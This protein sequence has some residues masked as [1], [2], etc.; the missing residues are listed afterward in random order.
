MDNTIDTADTLRLP[1]IKKNNTSSHFRAWRKAF[2]WLLAWEVY[3]ILLLATFLRFYQC[4]TTEFDGDQAAIYSLARNALTHGLIPVTT[5]LASIRILNPPA[6]VYLLMLGAAF[7]ANPFAGVIVT[8]IFNVLA[9]LFTYLV[10]SRYYGRVAG[11]VAAL[12][13]ACAPLAIFYSGFLWNQNL[14]APFVPLFVWALFWGVI[15]RRRGWLA[16]AVVLWGWMIQ[17]HGSAVLLIIPLGVACLL[18]FKTL[19]WRDL[20]LALGLLIL[21][22]APYIIWEMISHFSDVP[23]LLKNIGTKS[24]IDNL[25]LNDYLSFLMPYTI[26]PTNPLT[27]QYRVYALLHWG[28]RAILLLAACAL[29]FALWAVCLKSRDLLRFVPRGEP[30]ATSASENPSSWWGKVRAWWTDVVETPWRCG[31]IILL[32]W[33]ILPILVLSHHSLRM[34][35]YYLLVLMPGPFILIGIF[36]AQVGE[37]VRHLHF[38]WPLTRF[39]FYGLLILL[40]GGLALGSFTSTLDKA[41]GYTTA[42]YTRHKYMYYTL[43]DTQNAINEADRLAQV[44]H[45]HHVYIALDLSTNDALTYLAEQMQTPYTTYDSSACLLLPGSTQ[46]PALMLFGPGDTL[47]ETT[48]VQFAD[49]RLVDEPARLGGPPFH[50]Y[51]VQPGASRSSSVSFVN[52][53]G[54]LSPHLKQFTWRN[55]APNPAK[56]TPQKMQITPR[57]LTSWTVLRNATPAYGTTYSYMLNASYHGKGMEGVTSQNDCAFSSLQFGEQMLTTFFVPAGTVALPTSLSLSGTGWTTTLS[58]PTYGPFH[59]QTFQTR[60]TPGIPL[61]SSAG[62][63]SI[64]VQG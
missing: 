16:P 25:A 21:I 19:R 49:A 48:M 36:S 17:L 40:A 34:F 37:W 56:D 22:Y 38:P 59:F 9:V 11:G 47:A 12:F 23:I 64:T 53:L 62:G 2:S 29:L 6:T 30:R 51:L 10:V 13:Y 45:V 8:G 39:A 31:L 60:L 46:G 33:Q 50:L 57:L 54:L 15:E 20:T 27:S 24:V 32:A 14:L 28:E 1:R 63:K 26:A 18:A 58:T 3:P 42:H 52:N 43:H 5:N 44:Y 61:V 7:T 35:D 4:S 41:S 55:A